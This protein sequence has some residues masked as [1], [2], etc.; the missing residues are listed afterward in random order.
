MLFRYS[1]LT[2]NGH[3]IHYDRDVC[4]SEG[5]GGLVVHGP[6]LATLLLDLLRIEG[7]Q[8]PRAFSCRAMAPVL[9]GEDF[10][11]CA[12]PTDGRADL[13]VRRADSALAMRAE[14]TL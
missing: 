7:G 2:F 13:W 12:A 5:Y 9:E 11:L 4:T 8:V 6:L 10:T 3:R 1:A 14:A